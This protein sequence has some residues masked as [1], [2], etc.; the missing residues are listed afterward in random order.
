MSESVALH[1]PAALQ[2]LVEFSL[3]WL[4]FSLVLYLELTSIDRLC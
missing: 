3:P 1:A 4:S 2:E